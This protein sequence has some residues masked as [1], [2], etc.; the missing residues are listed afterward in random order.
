MNIHLFVLGVVTQSISHHIL[1]RVS[2]HLYLQKKLMFLIYT[3]QHTF[4]NTLIAIRTF[5]T[6]FAK[7]FRFARVQNCED[8]ELLE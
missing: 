6:R 7:P 4:Q 8:N 5:Q 3:H 1:G 2:E